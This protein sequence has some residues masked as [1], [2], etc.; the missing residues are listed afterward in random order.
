M[1]GQDG[2][3]L[4]NELDGL[5]GKLDQ[6]LGRR[7]PDAL[8]R[9]RGDEADFPV[10]TEVV[11]EATADR[12]PAPA[13]PSSPAPLDQPVPAEALPKEVPPE[14]MAAV[15][16]RLFGLLARQQQEVDETVRRI[17]QEELAKR[18]GR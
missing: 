15:E 5:Y 13:A 1:P 8:T 16:A 14:V 11:E 4:Y 7:G 9:H 12:G 10:L 3:D 6:L 18:E 17:I 2:G